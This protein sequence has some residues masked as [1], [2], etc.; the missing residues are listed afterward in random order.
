[1]SLSLDLATAVDCTL[2]DIKPT[3]IESTI[4]GPILI[5]G[6]AIGGLLI[7]RSS[8][9]LKGLNIIPG[10]ID[11]DCTGV[12]KI[13]L[14]TQFPPIHI[15]AGSRIVQLIPLPQ[16]TK[17]I[18]PHN[19]TERKEGGFGSTGPA[20]LLTFSMTARPEADISLA[21]GTDK[22]QVRMLLD[23]GTDISIVS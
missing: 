4:K 9:A 23:T 10:L 2:V 11:A 7:G 15:P 1:G 12:M 22:I 21:M 18:N 14:Q 5:N 8:S 20:A 6:Q 19:T 17:N 3:T 16:L 13:M